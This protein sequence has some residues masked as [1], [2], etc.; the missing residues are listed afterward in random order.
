MLFC[1]FSAVSASIFMQPHNHFGEK[2]AM[3]YYELLKTNVMQTQSQL[4]L[5][6]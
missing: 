5:K 4:H 1:D 6:G 3:N 2:N